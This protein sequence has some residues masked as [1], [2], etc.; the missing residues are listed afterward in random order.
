MKKRQHPDVE[1]GY[2]HHMD[3]YHP[4]LLPM[5]DIPMCL[6]YGTFLVKRRFDVHTGVDLYAPVDANVYAI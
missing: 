6:H 2:K 5:P 4:P 3:I 1:E